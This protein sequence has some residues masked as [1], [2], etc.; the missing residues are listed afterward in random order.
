MGGSMEWVSGDLDGWAAS[1]KRSET[2][3]MRQN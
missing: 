2:K 3:I 1:L